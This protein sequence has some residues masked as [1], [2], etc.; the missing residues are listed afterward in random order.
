MTRAGT[1]AAGP[2]FREGARPRNELPA[3]FLHRHGQ[4]R[5]ALDPTLEG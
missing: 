5:A 2:V 4:T 3:L 1:F